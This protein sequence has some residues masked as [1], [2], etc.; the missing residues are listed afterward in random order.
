MRFKRRIPLV[1]SWLF[2]ISVCFGC[3]SLPVEERTLE[4]K[5]ENKL[6]D[7]DKKLARMNEDI[8]RK[9]LSRS[10]NEITLDHLISCSILDWGGYVHSIT[11]ISVQSEHVIFSF[12]DV[13]VYGAARVPRIGSEYY[14]R[15]K[16]DFERIASTCL[17]PYANSY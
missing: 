17:Q 3:S 5:V 1:V 7:V 8:D 2:Y 6:F 11:T 16:S 10:A 4:L 13:Q 14:I 15:K 12:K 9:I